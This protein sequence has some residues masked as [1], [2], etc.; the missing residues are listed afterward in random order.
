MTKIVKLSSGFSNRYH[1]LLKARKGLLG[2]IVVDPRIHLL[3]V[4]S[5]EFSW[6]ANSETTAGSSGRVDNGV[7][8]GVSRKRVGGQLF[9]AIQ[10]E[11]AEIV[12]V[13][14]RVEAAV[15]T[16]KVVIQGLE[17]RWRE[18]PELE[19]EGRAF[20]P[21]GREV[22]GVTAEGDVHVLQNEV[23]AIDNHDRRAHRKNSGNHIFRD[24]E[25]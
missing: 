17:C 8:E 25:P 5:A 18:H 23:G 12:G 1:L 20:Y 22:G 7:D 19:K 21:R 13:V 9:G 11:E 3:K 2:V 10:G 4:V 6:V 15:R 24:F 14:P 16:G